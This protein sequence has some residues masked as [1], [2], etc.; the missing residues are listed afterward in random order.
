M[1][2]YCF[3]LGMVGDIIWRMFVLGLIV[4]LVEGREIRLSGK[5]FINL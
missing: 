5:I 4:E 2:F 1:G 3:F